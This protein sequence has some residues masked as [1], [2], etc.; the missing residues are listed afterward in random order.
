MAKFTAGNISR[1]HPDWRIV[2]AGSHSEAMRAAEVF[3]PNAAIIDLILPDGNGFDLLIELR[4]RNPSLSP[5][6]L[7]PFL[8]THR[9]RKIVK[10]R[11]GFSVLEKTVDSGVL[12]TTIEQALARSSQ[13]QSTTQMIG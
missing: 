8:S 12:V 4:D 1:V 7:T 9:F 2:L 10:A 3:D 11:G 5:I 6:I 13:N